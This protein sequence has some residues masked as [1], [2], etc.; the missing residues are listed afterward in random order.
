MYRHCCSSLS[1]HDFAYSITR[2]TSEFAL[3][4][5]RRL[6]FDPTRYFGNPQ[7]VHITVIHVGQVPVQLRS[8]EDQT[9][10]RPNDR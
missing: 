6:A 3:P 5:S 10:T 9:I 2:H 8:A 4:I 7:S 1:Y